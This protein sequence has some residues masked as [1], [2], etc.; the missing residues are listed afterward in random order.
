MRGQTYAGDEFGIKL[1]FERARRE[2]PSLLVLEDLD[3]L[4]TDTNRAFFLNEVDGIEDNDGLLMIGTTN[5]FDK[6][7]TAISS[8][9][10]RFDRK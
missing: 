8:R 9:P 6:L 10:S 2:A 3:S 4:I 5:H 7:D 1:I